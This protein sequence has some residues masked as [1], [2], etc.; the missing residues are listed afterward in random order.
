[1]HG[2]EGGEGLFP[3]RPLS[4]SDSVQYIKAGNNAFSRPDVTLLVRYRNPGPLGQVRVNWLC[5]KN[6]LEI[7][8]AQP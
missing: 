1:M 4:I 5:L 7:A 6:V 2:S 8:V 3:S